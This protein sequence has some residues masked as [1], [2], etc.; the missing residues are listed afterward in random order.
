MNTISTSASYIGLSRLSCRAF[1]GE[2]EEYVGFEG[3]T[4]SSRDEGADFSG[5]MT[6]G[7]TGATIAGAEDVAGRA[8]GLG[9]NTHESA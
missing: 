2:G 8:S 5:V 3:V 4:V 1:G 7:A 6:T 9:V